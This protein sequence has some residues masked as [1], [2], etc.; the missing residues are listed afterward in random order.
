MATTAYAYGLTYSAQASAYVGTTVT[1]A[2]A[3]TGTTA[4]IAQTALTANQLASSPT[5]QAVIGTYTTVTGM[6]GAINACSTD[7]S[8]YACAT[9]MIVGGGQ[10]AFVSGIEETIV[11]NGFA[12]F[13][14]TE[15]QLSDG[16]MSQRPDI[17]S[18]D[19]QY[20]DGTLGYDATFDFGIPGI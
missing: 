9:S 11:T 3:G 10:V 8:S 15:N 13:T 19:Y 18:N 5:G 17:T 20:Q 1:T 14:N 2:A 7:P 4:V 6:Y 16:G 12:S